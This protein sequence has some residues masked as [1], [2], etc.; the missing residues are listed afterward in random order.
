MGT[1]EA[2][3]SVPPEHAKCRLWVAGA[4]GRIYPLDKQSNQ[5]ST[6][7]SSLSESDTLGEVSFR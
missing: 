7:W 3:T 2:K 4:D 1:G 5:P 6:H